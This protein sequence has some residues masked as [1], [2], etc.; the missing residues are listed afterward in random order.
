MRPIPVPQFTPETNE[1]QVE[2]DKAKIHPVVLF[3]GE[4]G[5]RTPGGSSVVLRR[6]ADLVLNIVAG[7]VRRPGEKRAKAAGNDVF[8]PM[9]TRENGPD[10]ARI[11]SHSGHKYP[12]R[13]YRFS[14]CAVPLLRL[15]LWVLPGDANLGEVL[16]AFASAS[17][18]ETWPSSAAQR[19]T[20]T[21]GSV[22]GRDAGEDA[23]RPGGLADWTFEANDGVHLREQICA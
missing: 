11:L 8:T 12:E 13:L 15:G 3:E 19:H 20:R 18:T 22:G 6:Y 23:L 4:A 16:V 9:S 17:I 21:R 1:Q 10:G 14:Q 5:V 2:Q 7:M